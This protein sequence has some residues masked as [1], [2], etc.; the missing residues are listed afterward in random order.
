D[1]GTSP[2]LGGLALA[3]RDKENRAKFWI[4]HD[5]GGVSL[6]RAAFG[7]MS[8]PRHVHNELVVAVTEDGAGRCVTRGVSDIGASRSIMVFNPGE[9]H[10]GGVAGDTT[11]RYRGLYV[12]DAAFRDI[13]EAIGEQPVATPYFSDSVVTDAELADLLVRAHIAL[14]TRDARLV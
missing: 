2:I 3:R 11:W 12:T 6:L 8:F 10:A 4:D 14:E 13:C 1:K 9:P 7:T 5:L